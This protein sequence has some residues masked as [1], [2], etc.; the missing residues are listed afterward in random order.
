MTLSRLNITKRN[1]WYMV[2]PGRLKVEFMQEVRLAVAA[3]FCSVV[4]DELPIIPI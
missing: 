4:N 3:S 2:I 1:N